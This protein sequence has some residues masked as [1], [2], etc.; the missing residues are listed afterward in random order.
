MQVQAPRGTVDIMPDVIYKWHYLEDSL[1]KKAINY[2]YKEI[3]TPIF[4]HTEVFSR[5][6]GSETDIVEKEMYTFPDRKGRSLTLRPE[7]TA[8]VVRA[9]LEHK[10]PQE[11]LWKV[12]YIAPIFRYE[13]PQAGRYR[14]HHQFGVEAIGSGDPALDAEIITLA[15][16]IYFEFGL[17]NLTVDINSIGCKEDRPIYRNALLDYL[18]DKKDALCNDCQR[19]YLNNPLRILDCK[20]TSC[21]N[22]ASQAPVMLDYLCNECKIHFDKL[23]LHLNGFGIAFNVNPYIVR[24]LDYYSRTVF[25]LKSEMLGAQNTLIGGGRYDYLMGDLGGKHVPA[26]GFGMGLERALM[27]VPE[28]KFP[29]MPSLKFFLIFMGEEAKEFSVRLL[30]D[31]RAWGIMADMDYVGKNVKAQFRSASR[32]GA[33]YCI[34]IGE[35]ELLDRKLALKCMKTGDQ[36]FLEA[37]D[38]DKLR[39]SVLKIIENGIINS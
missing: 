34:I 23:K 38:K 12:F 27:V 30:R 31:L 13:R 29:S 6:I 15:H 4:E 8:P 2:G 9:Y 35:N 22:I 10:I 5:S 36:S 20:N 17:K 1:R 26:I 16:D 28:E 24:G 19:R 3:R 11:L 14:Q 39:E 37:G 25:E 18:N 32:L 33:E 7:G 21:G